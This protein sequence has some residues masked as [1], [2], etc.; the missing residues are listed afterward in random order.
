MIQIN[1]IISTHLKDLESNLKLDCCDSKFQIKPFKSLIKLFDTIDDACEENNNFSWYEFEETVDL[2][3]KFNRPKGI[4]CHKCKN[5][6]CIVSLIID[7]SEN[8]RFCV[9]GNVEIKIN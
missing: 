5:Q 9:A 4:V 8:T 3:T 2:N 7:E 6:K 1:N